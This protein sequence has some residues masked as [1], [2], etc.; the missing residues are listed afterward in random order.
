MRKSRRSVFG[1]GGGLLMIASYLLIVRCLVLALAHAQ[2]YIVPHF[3]TKV[4]RCPLQLARLAHSGLRLG[5]GIRQKM[6]HGLP[7]RAR[8]R[9]VGRRL[10]GNLRR[11]GP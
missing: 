1:T 6:G 8:R 4:G 3:P 11:S 7:Q 10:T 2:L 9:H 5:H